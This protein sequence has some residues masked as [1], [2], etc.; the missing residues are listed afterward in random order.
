MDSVAFHGQAAVRLM[1]SYLR[2]AILLEAYGD[3]GSASKSAFAMPSPQQIEEAER[4]MMA[5]LRARLD[6][7][8]ASW[9]CRR[10]G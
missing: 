6:A 5:D 7:A 10:L 9:N 1:I 4:L 2:P 8:Q 3:Q